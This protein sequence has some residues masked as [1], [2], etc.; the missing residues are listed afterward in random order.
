MILYG[1]A[2]LAKLCTKLLYT[3][4]LLQTLAHHAIRFVQYGNKRQTALLGI[5]L[6]K[7]K[8]MD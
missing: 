7:N 4:L 1:V 5:N 2:I 8:R 6:T 3:A